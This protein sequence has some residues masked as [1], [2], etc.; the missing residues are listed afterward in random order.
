MK[1]GNMSFSGGPMG[2]T[3][4]CLLAWKKRRA[5]GANAIGIMSRP[6]LFCWS[7]FTGFCRSRLQLGAC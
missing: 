5:A 6:L 2:L 1:S 4:V 7:S 3:E